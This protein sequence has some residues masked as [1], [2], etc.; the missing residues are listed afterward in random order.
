MMHFSISYG[1]IKGVHCSE[2]KELLTNILR[3]EWKFKG[4]IVSDWYTIL[5]IYSH[6]I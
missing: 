6:V 5:F 1:R 4:I 3:G 2:N